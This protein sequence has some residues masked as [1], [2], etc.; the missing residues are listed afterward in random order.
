MY[1]C[2]AHRLICTETPI[3]V[4][5]FARSESNKLLVNL[6]SANAPTSFSFQSDN[7]EQVVD[8]SGFL[9]EDFDHFGVLLLLSS[10]FFPWLISVLSFGSFAV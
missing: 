3:Y 1:L 7:C 5:P 4:R 10:Q 9:K 6:I 8:F 2:P